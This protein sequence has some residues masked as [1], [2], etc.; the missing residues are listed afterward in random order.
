MRKISKRNK[1]KKAK[2]NRFLKSWEWTTLRYKMLQKYD[3]RCMCCGATPD[4]G[5]T[6]LHVDHIKPRHKF[7]RLSLDESNL[8]VLCGACNQGKGSWD[9]T[10]FRTHTEDEQE[11]KF[12]IEL[13]RIA[14][15]LQ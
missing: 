13:E 7:P 12:Q 3:R 15:M 6:I 8:Q 2:S 9:E 5:I 10:D 4:D 1:R 11:R 14:E